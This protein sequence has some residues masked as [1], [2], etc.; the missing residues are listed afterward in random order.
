[1]TDYHWKQDPR[2]Q[3]LHAAAQ[4]ASQTLRGDVDVHTYQS[5]WD[6]YFTSSYWFETERGVVL[7]DTQ[8]F[9][10]A[11]E[12]LWREIERT[13]SGDL[14]FVVNTHAHPDHYFGNTYLREVAP[15]ATIISS[16]GVRD[17]MLETM[18]ARVAKTRSEWGD[19][20]T[21]D[22]STLVL[23]DVAFDGSLSLEFQDISLEL[24][25]MGPAEAPV[26]VVGWIPQHRALVTADIIQNRQHHY[27]SD[28]T[29]V[30]WL[31]ILAELEELEPLHV[32]SGHQ[33]IAGP[34]IFPETKAWISTYLG[35]MARHLP[36]GADPED[37]S[38]LD[39]AGRVQVREELL[40]ALPDWYDPYFFQGK[41][42]VETCLEGQRSEVVGAD[43]LRRRQEA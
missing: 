31:G 19:E 8:I 33:G 32:L 14:R 12:E 37:I 1:V 13:T 16:R 10:S 7:V 34:S 27:F 43:I 25:E 23:P 6:P 24:W 42:V 28:R 40:A 5:A 39:E 2:W 30:P 15:Q 18:A 35:L 22:P 26:Q 17:D 3:R 9:R 4:D 38:A 21:D 41:T 20:V 11:V 36:A 29:L